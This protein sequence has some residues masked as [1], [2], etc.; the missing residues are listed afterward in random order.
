MTQVVYLAH[1]VSGDVAANIAR[2][3]RWLRWLMDNEPDVA[4]CCPWLPYLDVLNED[5]A[6]H[7]ARGLRDDV[8]IA[9]RCDGIVLCG[10]RLSGGMAL[11]RD[12]VIAAGGFVIDLTGFGDEPVPGLWRFAM[13]HGLRIGEGP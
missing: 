13:P 6:E 9:K 2:A 8:E 11:E 12:A 3:M 1:P 5:N 7:R 10:G 4:F